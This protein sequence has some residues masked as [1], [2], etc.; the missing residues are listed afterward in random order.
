MVPQGST[1]PWFV[2]YGR[3]GGT[4]ANASE[5]SGIF[6]HMEQNGLLQPERLLTGNQANG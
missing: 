6:E 3:F 2:G 4:R 5:L 1:L